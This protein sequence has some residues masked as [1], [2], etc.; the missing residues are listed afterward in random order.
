MCGRKLTLEI[1]DE[2]VEIC[3]REMNTSE[4]FFSQGVYVCSVRGGGVREG[5]C[6]LHAAYFRFPCEEHCSGRHV[7]AARLKV[8][9]INKRNAT[10]ERTLWD[11][12][13]CVHIEVCVGV[14]GVFMESDVMYVLQ[15]E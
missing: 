14:G 9:T 4:L 1:C 12:Q 2:R 7:C 3:A 10:K 13:A 6:G 15:R 8:S 11:K 5:C